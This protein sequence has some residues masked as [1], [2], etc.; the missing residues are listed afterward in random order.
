[1]DAKG[2]DHSCTYTSKQLPNE[3]NIWKWNYRRK[4]KKVTEI[5]GEN[6]T[7]PSPKQGL[8]NLLR[9]SRTFRKVE[10][11][12]KRRKK[13]G[14]L[15]ELNEAVWQDA[16]KRKVI[17]L[18]KKDKEGVD[19]SHFDFIIAHPGA[20]DHHKTPMAMLKTFWKMFYP[21]LDKLIVEYEDCV[22]NHNATVADT[23]HMMAKYVDM[24]EEFKFKER[25][26][27]E[28][29]ERKELYDRERAQ[30][31]KELDEET[32]RIK[33]EAAARKKLSEQSDEQ[34]KENA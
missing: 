6:S 17:I 11:S 32:E 9:K 16:H 5:I 13:A 15:A 14:E 10:E 25:F 2:K 33:K 28:N 20:W 30:W 3:R 22:D 4:E 34:A 7:Q 19:W 8:G 18:G 26:I 23:D 1:M 21:Y 27:E 31:K 12:L 24:I 29:P